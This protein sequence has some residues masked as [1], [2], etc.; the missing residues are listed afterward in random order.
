LRVA[1]SSQFENSGRSGPFLRPALPGRHGAAALVAEVGL[2][3]LQVRGA[4]N[5]RVVRHRAHARRG[6]DIGGSRTR[7][8]GEACA[9]RSAEVD[10]RL[11]AAAVVPSTQGCAIAIEVD[12][13]EHLDHLNGFVHVAALDPCGQKRAS[14]LQ[15]PFEQAEVLVR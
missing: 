11:A 6:L 1:S 10:A 13:I 8:A 2:A 12:R 3:G 9:Q 15:A 4:Q 5:G 7:A 14:A